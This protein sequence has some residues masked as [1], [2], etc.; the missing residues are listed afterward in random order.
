MRMTGAADRPPTRDS[1]GQ[2]TSLDVP[3]FVP[4][5]GW[6]LEKCPS[7]NQAY[8]FFQGINIVCG[9]VMGSPS[10]GSREEMGVTTRWP[11]WGQG[12]D[13]AGCVCRHPSERDQSCHQIQ[14]HRSVHKTHRAADAGTSPRLGQPMPLTGRVWLGAALA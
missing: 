10:E 5:T 8:G 3:S 1:Q 11:T 4:I 13:G 12:G 14:S 6:L 7:S 2:T 9:G